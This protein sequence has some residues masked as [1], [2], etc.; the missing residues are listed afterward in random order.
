MTYPFIQVMKSSFSVYFTGDTAQGTG[1]CDDLA[2]QDLTGNHVSN[3]V[4]ERRCTSINN[5]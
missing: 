4:K 1:K 5:L 2:I 3:P